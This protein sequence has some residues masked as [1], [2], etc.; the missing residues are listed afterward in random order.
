M[1]DLIDRTEGGDADDDVVEVVGLFETRHA[2]DNAVEAL[3]TAGV[4]RTAISVLATH[5]SIEASEPNPAAPQDDA[6]AALVGE[7]TYAFPL[8]SA[9]LLTVVGGPITGTIG[10][11]MAA[12]IGGMAFKE[13]LD[14]LTS[15]PDAD[16]F[17][18]ALEDGGLVVWVQV[19]DEKEE[20]RVADI[21]TDEGAINIHLSR[22]VD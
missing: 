13:Y 19:D 15:H 20:S 12:G 11:L 18:K 8:E 7:L 2:F 22:R 21:L 10:A 1:S 9:G 5:T 17:A 6:L 14:E 16:A 3:L 4:P